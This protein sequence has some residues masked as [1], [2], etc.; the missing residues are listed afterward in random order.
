MQKYR[1]VNIF[2]RGFQGL[3]LPLS[4][5]ATVLSVLGAAPTSSVSQISWKWKDLAPWETTTACTIIVPSL[6]ETHGGTE[7]EQATGCQLDYAEDT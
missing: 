3:F 4:E 2:S 5:A 1:T 6:W 7:W